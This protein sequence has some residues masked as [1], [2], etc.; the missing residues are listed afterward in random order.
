MSSLWLS[1]D[2]RLNVT[3]SCSLNNAAIAAFKN[4]FHYFRIPCS[5]KFQ[6]AFFLAFLFF[7][8]KETKEQVRKRGRYPR[9]FYAPAALVFRSGYRQAP[10]PDCVLVLLILDFSSESK[11][12]F[13]QRRKGLLVTPKRGLC[14]RHS[15]LSLTPSTAFANYF[16]VRAIVAV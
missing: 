16:R 9:R 15:H 5:L 11:F 3:P 14:L 13:T 6:G 12:L 4:K 10:V 8:R 2:L 1:F 7:G